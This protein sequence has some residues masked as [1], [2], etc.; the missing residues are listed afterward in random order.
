MWDVAVAALSLITVLTLGPALLVDHLLARGW[1]R[2]PTGNPRGP[3]KLVNPK[4]S[5]WRSWP[6]I[7]WIAD[8]VDK[9]G[10]WL[11]GMAFIAAA[12]AATIQLLRSF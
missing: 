12:S 6:L 4:S 7:T 5:G 2:I 11:K 8:R 10:W 9:S 1:H 3:W